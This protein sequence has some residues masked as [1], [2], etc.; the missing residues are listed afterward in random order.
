MEKL[1]KRRGKQVV[2]RH[3][4]SKTFNTNDLIKFPAIFHFRLIPSGFISPAVKKGLKIPFWERYLGWNGQKKPLAFRSHH[5]HISPSCII[6]QPFS[7][8]SA[9]FLSRSVVLLP[10][11][12]RTRL[13]CAQQTRNRFRSFARYCVPTFRVGIK[14]EQEKSSTILWVSSCVHPEDGNSLG[15]IRLIDFLFIC[16]PPKA[17]ENLANFVALFFWLTLQLRNKLKH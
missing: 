16:L 2:C 6:N 17:W 13:K 9:V 1:A 10:Y 5:H 4:S 11:E 15:S 7:E 14:P 12:A 8:F 3:R